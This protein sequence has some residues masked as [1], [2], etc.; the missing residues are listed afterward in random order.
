MNIWLPL[1]LRFPSLVKLLNPAA[2][3]R[4]SAAEW[5][6]WICMAHSVVHNISN[7]W[8]YINCMPPSVQNN[9]QPTAWQCGL[10]PRDDCYCLHAPKLSVAWFL[11]LKQFWLKPPCTAKIITFKPPLDCRMTKNN[12]VNSCQLAW[13]EY[14]LCCGSNTVVV[15]MNG[16]NLCKHCLLSTLSSQWCIILLFLSHIF[17]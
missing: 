2:L 16:R 17:R 6:L 15:L 14:E 10:P 8:D 1:H 4:T 3:S 9:K 5:L 7:I 11:P 12:W 13:E